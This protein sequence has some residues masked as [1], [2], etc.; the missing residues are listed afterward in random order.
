MTCGC[1]ASSSNSRRSSEIARVRTSSPTAV[2][3]QTE[4]MSR[5]FGTICPARSARHTR[6]SITLGSRR[7]MPFGPVTRL[8]DGST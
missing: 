6:T 7:V 2:S 5:S 3:A 8:S 1:F 4:A